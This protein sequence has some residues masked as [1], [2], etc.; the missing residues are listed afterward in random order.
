MFYIC[1]ILPLHY[2]FVDGTRV[3]ERCL[4]RL[5][6]CVDN[7]AVCN[8]TVCVC[9][10]GFTWTGTICGKMQYHNVR[11]TLRQIQ[12]KTSKFSVCSFTQTVPRVCEHKKIVI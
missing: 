1:N 11:K 9:V 7:W 12:N 6:T 5:D 3:T 8:G 10:E 4:Q 2:F